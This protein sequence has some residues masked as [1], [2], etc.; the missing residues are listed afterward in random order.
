[1]KRY[2]TRETAMSSERS[3]QETQMRNA[4][5]F[6]LFVCLCVAV[7]LFTSTFP[8]HR[9]NCELC[10]RSALLKKEKEALRS[11]ND[12]LKAEIIALKTDT[13][14]IEAVAREKYDLV[15]NGETLIERDDF[16][17]SD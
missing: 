10:T 17:E 1:M 4:A 8:N 13:F 7:M 3:Q 11:R 16:G 12:F 9:R 14:Y 5:C 15:K 6:F 2:R